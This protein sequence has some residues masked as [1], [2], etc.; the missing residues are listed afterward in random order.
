MASEL[1]DGY[2]MVA[3]EALSNKDSETISKSPLPRREGLRE[4]VME[5]I[6][7]QECSYEGLAYEHGAEL[8]DDMECLVCLNG[9]WV[10]MDNLDSAGC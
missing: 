6:E 7:K 10:N 8:C 1:V 9:R 2:R 3:T 4:G 5:T